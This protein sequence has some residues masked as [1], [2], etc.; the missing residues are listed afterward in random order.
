MLATP[1]T[2]GVHRDVNPADYH[3]WDL[4]SFHRLR[5]MQRSAAHARYQ[6]DHQD[7]TEAMFIGEAVHCC[8]LQPHLFGARYTV[9]PKCDRRTKEGKATWASFQN[10]NEGK[11]ILTADQW[12]SIQ[13]M[14]TALHLH[15]LAAPFLNNCIADTEVSLVWDNDGLLCKGRIDKLHHD[16]VSV[17]DLKT[18]TDA[19]PAAFEREIFR[20]GYH[21]QGAF[22]L[23]ALARFDGQYRQFAWVLVAVEKEPPHGIVVY[24][25]TDEALE[26]GARE[27]EPLIAEYRECVRSGVWPS[28]KLEVNEIGLPK[29]ARGQNGN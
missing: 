10:E 21:Q 13:E 12:D 2:V 28:Y 22:Y 5:A 17:M 16:F 20:F 4:C 24:R 29:W 7:Q 8:A 6:M 14:V 19:S 15:P 3:S 27:L 1:P 25:I 9:A 23:D 11:N 18:T 26:Q